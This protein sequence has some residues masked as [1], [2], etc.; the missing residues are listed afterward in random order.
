MTSVQLGGGDFLRKKAKTPLCEYFTAAGALCRLSTNCRKILDAAGESFIAAKEPSGVPDFFLRVWVDFADGGQAPWPKP[1]VRG[2]DH[3]VFAGFDSGSTML[4][5]LR[6]RQ[7]IGRFSAGM[8]SDAKHWKTVIFPI[9]L[10][11][12]SASLGVAELH[13]ACVAKGEDGVLLVGPSGSG[14]STLTLA[15][16]QLG[17]GFLSDDRTFCSLWN[18]E[19]HAWGLSTLLK[20]RQSAVAWFQELSAQCPTGSQ[21]RDHDL[22]LEPEAIA[23]ERARRCRLRAVIF[24]ERQEAPGFHWCPL[25]LAEAL[26][27]L[28]RDLMPESPGHAAQRLETMARVV[29]LPCL[30]LRYGGAP[31]AVARNIA[32]WLDATLIRQSLRELGETEL[33]PSRTALS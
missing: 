5:D 6:T 23:I 22:W 33:S 12:M 14:K 13:C 8:A 4:A 26:D 3:L 7:V 28:S 24:L 10:T 31:Q 16:A 11:I 15:L 9:L 2:L 18:G 1:Y 25:P 29:A 27:L 30:R 20:L 19:A 17:F 32:S 21:L